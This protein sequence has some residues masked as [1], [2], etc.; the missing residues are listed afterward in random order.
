[1][2]SPIVDSSVSNNKHYHDTLKLNTCL[3]VGIS[4][5]IATQ[6]TH[7]I[8]KKTTTT[9]MIFGQQFTDLPSPTKDQSLGISSKTTPQRTSRWLNLL[10]ASKEASQIVAKSLKLN[11]CSIGITGTTSLSLTML[12]CSTPE[13]SFHFLY[14]MKHLQSLH[15]AHQGITSMTER[16]KAGIFW[17]G[18]TSEIQ[19]IRQHCSSCNRSVPSQTKTPPIEPWIPSTPFKAI[20]CDYFHFRGWY[21]FVAADQLSGWTE[22]SRIKSGTDKAGSK[23]LCKALRN[24]FSTFGV[25]VEISSD[26]G[27]ELIAKETEKFLRRWEVRH[28]ISSA[29][30]PS[31]NGR[32]ELAMKCTKRLSW[33]TLVQ[34]VI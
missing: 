6:P 32:A 7:R 30:F 10:N 14:K 26:E 22:Q 13:S 31:S 2:R 17:P 11:C 23:G 19:R 15:S 21:Y 24:L 4:S 28:R 9:S 18:I 12:F 5:L 16:A 29:H 33:T 34:K 20:A 27:P 1:M 8:K 25:P 3:A